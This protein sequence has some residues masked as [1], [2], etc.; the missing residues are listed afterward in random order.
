MA[1]VLVDT[2]IWRKYFAG[3][4]ST[5]GLGQLLDEDAVLVHPFVLGELII[6]GLS[7]RE[8]SIFRR[9][10]EVPVVDHAE[11]LAFVAE[12]RL[13]RKGL[14][15]VDVHLLAAALLAQ[16]RLW[17]ADRALTVAARSLEVAFT[18]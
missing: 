13:T 10:P 11:I 8:A 9:L 14:G 3:V 12:R 17:S 18:D 4:S 5:R 7:D 1:G 6:G 15:W 16:A 2:S